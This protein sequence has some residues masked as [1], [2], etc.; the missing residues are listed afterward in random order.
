MNKFDIVLFDLGNTLIYFDGIWSQVLPECDLALLRSLQASGLRIE[1]QPFL[2]LVGE[3]FYNYTSQRDTEFIEITTN[4]VVRSVLAELG[5][6]E[7]E[8]SIL[9]RAVKA[10]YS[11]SQA[12]W[13]REEDTLPA[14][15]RLRQLGFRLGLVSNASDD[16]D[17]QTLVDK[18]QIRPYFDILVTSAAQGI[19]KP[20]PRIFQT[21]LNRWNAS[22]SQAVM[23]GD[24]LGADILGAKNAGIY[25]VWITRRAAKPGNQDHLDTIQPDASIAN[26]NE[27]LE[28]LG[29]VNE[30]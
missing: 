28:L 5:V 18:A 9:R 14:L 16:E 20:N 8:T 1:D 21:A 19:R 6:P 4:H 15:E 3:Q 27:L 26:L 30:G 12:H 29:G 2:D 7:V 11:V 22:P 10:M 23:V 25:S 24:T 17:V 13:I